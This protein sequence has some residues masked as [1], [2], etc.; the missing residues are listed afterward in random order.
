MFIFKR[1]C[2]RCEFCPSFFKRIY[3][4][5]PYGFHYKKKSLY[6]IEEKKNMLGPV[7]PYACITLPRLNSKVCGF[8]H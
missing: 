6:I 1:K 5:T 7:R 2:I 3:S 4:S 8:N